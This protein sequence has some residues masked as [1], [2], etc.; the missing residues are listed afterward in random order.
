[1]NL[2]CLRSTLCGLAP[3][4]A[5]F[6]LRK[7]MPLP[8]FQ[9]GPF[10]ES[11]SIRPPQ[12]PNGFPAMQAGVFEKSV[13]GRGETGLLAS[14]FA[15]FCAPLCRVNAP[16]SRALFG[17]HESVAVV[18][19][20]DVSEEL[21]GVLDHSLVHPLFDPAEVQPSVNIATRLRGRVPCLHGVPASVGDHDPGVR[22]ENRSMG[23]SAVQQTRRS[24]YRSRFLADANTGSPRRN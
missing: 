13:V 23:P 15:K 22:Q 3:F 2:D 5:V 10:I 7:N 20:F 16:S 17:G 11:E 14:S 8:G 9:V 18:S 21:A 12:P 24:A 6:F 19:S 1:M 4:T